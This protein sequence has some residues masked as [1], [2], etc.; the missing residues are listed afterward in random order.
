MEPSATEATAELVRRL[1]ELDTSAVSDASDRL[2]LATV[3]AAC[4]Q[5]RSGAV[6]GRVITVELRR[7]GAQERGETHLCS[8]AIARSG[9]Q[10]VIV[11]AN[12]GRRD[13][14]AWGGLLS[15]GAHQR[16]AR[17]AI[18]DGVVR[19]LDEAEAIGFPLY[20]LGTSPVTARGRTVEV[21][22][23]GPI[24][25]DGVLVETGDLVIADGTGVAFLPAARAQ[26]LID[27]AESVAAR[28]S[29]M[30]ADIGRG[31]DIRE[32]LGTDYETLLDGA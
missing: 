16:Q 11:V 21:A 29:A 9:P 23:G 5:W 32:V 4:A 1:E 15:R 14:G 24:R 22:T 8:E 30:A 19:D 2:G 26:E 7:A 25:F 31:V 12:N 10:D 18:V 27:V 13:S 6:V 20:A 3:V 28:E 17:G